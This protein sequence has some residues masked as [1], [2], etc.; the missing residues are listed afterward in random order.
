MRAKFM[1]GMVLMAG[2]LSV[3]CGG[4]VANV[5]EQSDLGTRED[6]LPACGGQ[7]YE[8]IFYA[9][10]EHIT[11]IGTWLCFCGDSSAYVYGRSSAYYEYTY[12]SY[13]AAAPADPR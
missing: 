10:P 5:E 6:A 4:A 7:Q 2:L 13:C 9:E 12:K 8:R 11:E 3:G 1:G